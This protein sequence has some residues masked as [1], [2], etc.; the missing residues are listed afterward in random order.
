MKLSIIIPIYNVR[1]YIV[2]CVESCICNDY[3]EQYEIILVNDETPDDSIELLQRF[4]QNYSNIK[5]INRKNGGLSAAR[6]SGLRASSGEYVWFVDGDDYISENAIP[7]VLDELSKRS[8]DIFV[9]HYNNI[10]EGDIIDSEVKFSLPEGIIDVRNSI[11]NQSISFPVL[12]WCH[13]YRTKYLLENNLT[14]YE[15]IL[16]EDVEFKFKSHYLANS[17]YYIRKPL[18]N[19]RTKRSGS[20]MNEMKRDPQ[21]S[22]ESFLKIINKTQYDMDVLNVNAEIR[23]NVLSTLAYLLV[24]IIYRQN[25]YFFKKNKIDRLDE[26]LEIV[27]KS[28]DYKKRIFAKFCS[29]IPFRI[30]QCF[31]VHHYKEI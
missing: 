24:L 18:Y 26:I 23:N 31:V 13:L 11:V 16:H 4:I 20:I 7:I 10:V 14:F 8:C 29:I 5:L 2:K 19:Y 21:R 28:S 15:G 3:L 9:F 12:V 6:N 30:V 25:L 22:I 27:K 17:L 1:D